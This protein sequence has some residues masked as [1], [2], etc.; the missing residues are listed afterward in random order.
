MSRPDLGSE[1]S[2][3]DAQP[4]QGGH[5]RRLRARTSLWK[6]SKYWVEGAGPGLQSQP[7]LGP[8]CTSALSEA[9]WTTGMRSLS[10]QATSHNNAGGN[11]SQNV[12]F[13]L[14]CFVF[15]GLHLQPME[16]PRLKVKSELQLLAYTIVTA[17]QD[18]RCVCDLHRSSQILNPPSEARDW[19]HILVTTSR[20]GT[21]EPCW[22]FQKPRF[23]KEMECGD[24]G[25]KC[26]QLRKTERKS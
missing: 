2:E 22:E 9:P 17:I 15:L 6:V 8:G 21:A 4:L 25:G 18:L 13:V 19:T 14:F 1:F 5:L 11:E 23:I 26:R 20:L 10:P 24:I 16:V 7:A 12:C 3:A